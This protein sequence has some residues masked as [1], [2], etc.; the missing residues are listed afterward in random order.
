MPAASASSTEFRPTTSALD[1][2]PGRPDPARLA[3]EPLLGRESDL[4]SRR[5]APAA[6]LRAAGCPVR[7]VARGVGPFPS[8]PRAFCPPE[9]TTAPFLVPG[10]REAP[11]RREFPAI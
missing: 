6:A 9:P 11:T 7:S 3:R 10:L 2:L 4:P 5:A 1:S 8:R